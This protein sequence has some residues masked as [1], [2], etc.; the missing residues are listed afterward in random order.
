MACQGK[1][2]SV[3]D[4]AS[5]TTSYAYDSFGKPISTTDAVGN[6]VTAAYDV[7]GRKTVPVAGIGVGPDA[8]HSNKK[9]IIY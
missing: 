9:T 1:V 6:I 2:V 5:H 3:T 7:R 8:V 4:A